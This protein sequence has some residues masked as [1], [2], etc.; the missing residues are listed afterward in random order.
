MEKIGSFSVAGMKNLQ[1][2]LNKVKEENIDIFIEQC[3]QELAARL[4]TKVIKRT[5]VG[6]YSANSGKKDQL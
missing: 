1:K 5:P 4:L 6:K 2:K 3:A